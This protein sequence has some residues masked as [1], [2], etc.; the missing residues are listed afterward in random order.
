ML[1]WATAGPTASPK[2]GATASPKAGTTASPRAGTTASP[3]A[4]TTA[5]P[6]AGTTVILHKSLQTGTIFMYKNQSPENPKVLR[7]G[8]TGRL[9]M[10]T[11]I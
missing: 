3:K 7:P 10:G 1:P 11:T 8:T 9:K 4:G 5:S 2:A 6:K